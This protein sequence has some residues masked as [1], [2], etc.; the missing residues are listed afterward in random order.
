MLP[1]FGEPG[2]HLAKVKTCMRAGGFGP[3]GGQE[4]NHSMTLGLS[5]VQ[6][7]CYG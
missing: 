4:T 6:V 1:V 5:Y 3:R 7:R 2:R